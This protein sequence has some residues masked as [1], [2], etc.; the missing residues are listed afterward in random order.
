M[1]DL[2]TKALP[3]QPPSGLVGFKIPKY[4]NPLIPITNIYHRYRYRTQIVAAKQ[5]IS[6]LK[7]QFKFIVQILTDIRPAPPSISN[8]AAPAITSNED[9]I[10]PIHK[11]FNDSARSPSS[12]T[13]N[14]GKDEDKEDEEEQEPFVHNFPSLL[15]A[16]SCYNP[17]HPRHFW[18]R[19]N[20]YF[21]RHLIILA[22]VFKRAIRKL[23][24]DEEILAPGIWKEGVDEVIQRWSINIR[25]R[26]MGRLVIHSF[27]GW[28]SG[29]SFEGVSPGFAKIT[30][31]GKLSVDE[32]AEILALIWDEE[33]TEMKPDMYRWAFPNDVEIL[34]KALKEKKRGEDPKSAGV[35]WSI[36][37]G[38]DRGRDKMPRNVANKKPERRDSSSGSRSPKKLGPYCGPTCL[39]RRDATTLEYAP[40]E[41]EEEDDEDDDIH[42]YYYS[43]GVRRRRTGY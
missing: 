28:E 15:F 33:I 4:L 7:S 39:R 40:T 1:N 13:P 35:I 2:H 19:F 5:Q 11:M 25:N 31:H 41:S 30:Q 42:S 26:R 36:K 12:R 38:Q 16:I 3:E 37:L 29:P 32:L 14:T 43:Q 23:E 9:D 21:D 34:D 18:H 24:Y 6:S 8:A 17:R 10:T 22:N 27:E 20:A